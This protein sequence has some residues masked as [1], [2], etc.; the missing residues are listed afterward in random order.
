MIKF[1]SNWIQ[2]IALAVIIASIFEMLL[3]NGNLK[4]Y[5]KVILGIYVIFSIIS[6]FVNKKELYALE[7]D[8]TIENYSENFSVN[9]IDSNQN[10]SNTDLEKIYKSTFEKE[11]KQTVEKQ[12][13]NV[14]KCIVVGIFDASK[15]DAGI[16]RIEVTLE[17]KREQEEVV[18]ENK[19]AIDKVEKV[20]IKIGENLEKANNNEITEKDIENLKKY[21]SKH[22][23]VDKNVIC[24]TKR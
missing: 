17:S 5:I 2:G 23:E 1:L 16:K 10:S 12:G 9:S 24:I 11:I 22:F 8:K 20:E 19:I 13:Y 18:V 7:V 6:P 4:K 14:H 3:P 15:K 21:L